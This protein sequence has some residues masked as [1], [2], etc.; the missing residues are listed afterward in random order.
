MLSVVGSFGR[1]FN[2]PRLHQFIYFQL[3]AFVIP[4][5]SLDSHLRVGRH[6]HVAGMTESVPVQV[7]VATL[8]CC[9][10]VVRLV[11]APGFPF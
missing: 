11:G 1:E 7:K 8:C 9:R 5:P 10:S 2:S 3:H 4:I 6:A